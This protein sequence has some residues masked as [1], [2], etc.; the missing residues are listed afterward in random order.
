[1]LATP[2]AYTRAHLPEGNMAPDQHDNSSGSRDHENVAA[3][4]HCCTYH[5]AN[6][7]VATLVDVATAT[8]AVTIIIANACSTFEPCAISEDVVTRFQSDDYE[9]C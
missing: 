4:E 3:K 1:M 5:T 8:A 7:R 2:A 6:A 9:S